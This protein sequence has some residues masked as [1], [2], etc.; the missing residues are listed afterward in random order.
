MKT[1]EPLYPEFGISKTLEAFRQPPCSPPQG[2]EILERYF[3]VF[4]DQPKNE[5]NSNLAVLH[6]SNELLEL[7]QRGDARIPINT[8][9]TL[10]K[11]VSDFREDLRSLSKKSHKKRPA[12]AATVNTVSI[13]PL[14]W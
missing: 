9:K 1:R 14:A 11:K 3:A 12:Y 7:W 5:R 4:H 2:K 13:V 8:L 6:V 10:K